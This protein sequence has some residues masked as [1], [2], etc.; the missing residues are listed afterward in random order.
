[1]DEIILA[2]SRL[3]CGQMKNKTKVDEQADEALAHE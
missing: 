2:Q 1:M 3:L